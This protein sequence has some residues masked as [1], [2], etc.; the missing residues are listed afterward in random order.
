MD[1]FRNRCESTETNPLALLSG[2]K[3]EDRE[4]LGTI[5][6]DSLC[7]RLVTRGL[8][9][10]FDRLVDDEVEQDASWWNRCR[11]GGGARAG[12]R[13]IASKDRALLL[14]ERQDP[15]VDRVGVQLELRGNRELRS[16]RP[17]STSHQEKPASLRGCSRRHVE[18]CALD[19]ERSTKS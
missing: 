11:D 1:G 8:R 12:I 15:V 9:T 7:L 17:T 6:E 14:L 4:V 2:S 3:D 19:F 18:V 16:E 5:E 10:T 13:P